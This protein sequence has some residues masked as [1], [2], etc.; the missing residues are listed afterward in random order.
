MADVT[1]KVGRDGEL[2]VPSDPPG[3]WIVWP[4]PLSLPDLGDKVASASQSPWSI[5]RWR[6]Q[7]SRGTRS[8][9]RFGSGNS[10]SPIFWKNSGR[11][12]KTVASKPKICSFCNPQPVWTEQGQSTRSRFP[13][14]DKAKVQWRIHDATNAKGL[15]YL[16]STVGGERI[17]LAREL[18][19]A[20]LVLTVGP[21]EF[22]PVAGYEEGVRC[23]IPACPMSKPS[24]GFTDKGIWN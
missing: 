13:E 20:D 15:A 22:D 12:S 21:I 11:C 5:P 9:D 18:I 16:S 17:Y 8:G 7:S 4:S 14:E 24:H 10:R 1:F 3:E 6:R 23:Y 2:Q 19:D